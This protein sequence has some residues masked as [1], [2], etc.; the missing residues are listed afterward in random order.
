MYLRVVP[1]VKR[2]VMTDAFRALGLPL[3][4][5]ENWDDITHLD[6]DA[7]EGH[8]RALEP[9]FDHPGLWMDFWTSVLQEARKA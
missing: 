2:S 7:L 4:A 3:L 6:E 5:V 9:G 1:I 8:Y